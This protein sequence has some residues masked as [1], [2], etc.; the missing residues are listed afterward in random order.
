MSDNEVAS[1]I[2]KLNTVTPPAATTTKVINLFGSPGSGKSTTAAGLYYNLKI[3]DY[4]CE[5]VREYIKSWAWEGRKP[6]EYDQVYIFGKQAKYESLLYGKVDYIITDSPL[7][8]SGFYEHYHQGQDIVGKAAVEFIDVAKKR[9]V[10]YLN[11]WLPSITIFDDRGRIHN[12]P[13]EISTAMYDWLKKKGIE[14]NSLN[15][16]KLEDRTNYILDLL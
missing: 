8:L 3:R 14:V 13:K 4:H 5:M 16:T 7:V 10:E 2:T 1:V 15:D 6:N 11:F 9:G 12:N